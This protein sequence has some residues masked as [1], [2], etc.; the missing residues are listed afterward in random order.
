MCEQLGVCSYDDLHRQE[1]GYV[2]VG[3]TGADGPYAS[4]VSKHT[5]RLLSEAPGEGGMATQL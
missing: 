5:G 3:R 4:T 2:Y 1:T